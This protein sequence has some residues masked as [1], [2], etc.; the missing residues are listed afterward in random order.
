MTFPTTAEWAEA[1]EAAAT[2]VLAMGGGDLPEFEP[3]QNPVPG[4][5]GAYISLVDGHHSVRL[6]I[7][8]SQKALLRIAEITNMGEL[9]EEDLKDA[10]C[11]LANVLGG[12]VRKFLNAK[13]PSLRLGLPMYANKEPATDRYD[14][15]RT[16]LKV[17]DVSA[18]LVVMVPRET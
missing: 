9:S 1:M 2:E 12:N 10:S 15:S 3:G 14:I 17:S 8:G 4:S 13:A 7:V 11:E 5:H 16:L 6:G 18:Q